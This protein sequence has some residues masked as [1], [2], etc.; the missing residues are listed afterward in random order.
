VESLNG[1]HKSGPRN[2]KR[3]RTGISWKNNKVNRPKSQL[4]EKHKIHLINF[5]DDHPQ[6]RVLDAVASLTEKFEDFKRNQR[7]KLL[8][9]G[10]QSFIQKNNP[11]PSTKK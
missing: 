8:E 5:Y 7:S 6:A 1:Q 9:K 11:S 3:I 10:L 4:E 2:S